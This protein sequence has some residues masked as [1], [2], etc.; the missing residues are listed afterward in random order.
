M[1]D[2]YMV[3]HVRDAWE[4]GVIAE[5]PNRWDSYWVLFECDDLGKPAREVFADRMEPEVRDMKPLVEELNAL[6]RKHDS[7][8]ERVQAV[9]ASTSEQWIHDLLHDVR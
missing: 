8:Q 4:Q 2:R 6:A 7:L 1:K 5:Q 3:L 9:L